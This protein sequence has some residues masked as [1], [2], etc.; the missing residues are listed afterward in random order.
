M[1]PFNLNAFTSVRGI[2]HAS[3]LRGMTIFIRRTSICTAHFRGRH[4]H[5]LDSI[6]YTLIRQ[7]SDQRL[8]PF[9]GFG[10]KF[11]TLI[12][13]SRRENLWFKAFDALERRW[14]RW[15]NWGK[16][17]GGH[18]PLWWL[19]HIRTLSSF[20]MSGFQLFH[21]SCLNDLLIGAGWHR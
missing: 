18:G 4:L 15:F 13:T 17:L 11:P 20:Y 2:P 1:F 14:P 7:P 8:V 6:S 16:F 3:V 9:P 19:L 5:N 12:T 10:A 21:T